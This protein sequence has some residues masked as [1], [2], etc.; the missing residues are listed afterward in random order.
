MTDY[1]R[2]SKIIEKTKFHTLKYVAKNDRF[3][4]PG[5]YLIYSTNGDNLLYIGNTNSLK[6]RMEEHMMGIGTGNFCSKIKRRP[7]LSQNIGNYKLRYIR[8]DN[9]RE[10]HFSE[11]CLIGVYEPPLNFTR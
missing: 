11:C 3:D 5:V 1:N 6:S 8:I 10:R 7:E 2:M 9:F 4:F